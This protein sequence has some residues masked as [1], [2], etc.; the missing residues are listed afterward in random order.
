MKRFVLLF[1]LA[2]TALYSFGQIKSDVKVID[3]NGTVYI[4]KMYFHHRIPFEGD[5]V[6]VYGDEDQP[7]IEFEQNSPKP[8]DYSSCTVYIP[9]T[10][11]Y[12]GK[13]YTVRGIG[14]GCFQSSEDFGAFHLP[15]TIHYIDYQAFEGQY[16][17]TSINIPE[18]V[19]RIGNDAFSR[20]RSLQ[21][22]TIPASVKTIG[23][24]F[25]GCSSISFTV[26][27]GNANYCSSY[28]GCLLNKAKTELICANKNLT[29]F[30]IPS[31]ITKIDANA[32]SDS[33]L[34]QL[35]I[36]S[37]VQYLGG[38]RDCLNLEKLTIPHGVK[39]YAYYGF[40]DCGKNSPSG[41]EL[42]IDCD[43]PYTDNNAGCY[44]GRYLKK[45]VFGKHVTKIP[46]SAFNDCFRI[47]TIVFTSENPPSATATDF[48]FEM[49][50]ED[51]DYNTN[52]VS[53]TLYVP[54]GYEDHYASWMSFTYYVIYD[55][56]D[57]LD[58]DIPC[59]S[60]IK[61]FF[62]SSFDKDDIKYNTVDSL[63]YIGG[64]SLPSSTTAVTLSDS[65][66]NNDSIFTV[67]GILGGAFSG[68]KLLRT[69]TIPTTISKIDST[70]FTNCVRLRNINFA[71][72]MAQWVNKAWRPLAFSDYTLKLNGEEVENAVIPEGITELKPYAFY[73]CTSMNTLTLPSTLKTI[74]QNAL[75]NCTS[76]TDIYSYARTPQTLNSI[77]NLSNVTVHVPSDLLSTYQASDWKKAKAIVADIVINTDSIR[78][79]EHANTVGFLK[80]LKL[81]PSFYPA[82]ATN[83]Y[84]NWHTSDSTIATVDSTGIVRA[85][86]KPGIVKI[87]ASISSDNTITD[88][89]TITVPKVTAVKLIVNSK[90]LAYNDSLKLSHTILPAVNDKAVVKYSLKGDPGFSV[91]STGL[92]TSTY[93]GKTVV[94]CTYDGDSTDFDSCI[95]NVYRDTI[96]VTNASAD[97]KAIYLDSI[98]TRQNSRVVASFLI[99]TDEAL[100]GFQA[101]ICLPKG[102]SFE[103]NSD[104]SYNCTPGSGTTS[105][106]D[107]QTELQA[108]NS[109][110]VLA[111]STTTVVPKCTGKVLL[112]LVLDVDSTISP[113]NFAIQL[114]NI[115]LSNVNG[116]LTKEA[117][118]TTLLYVIN[119]YT[120]ITAM[121]DVDN[122]GSV[123]SAD[124][125][126]V[127]NK[128]LNREVPVFVTKAADLDSNGEIL[129]NDA[130]KVM[131]IIVYGSPSRSAKTYNNAINSEKSAD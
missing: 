97:A 42:D 25:D 52:G 31:T 124:A 112:T 7:A 65:V 126:L 81:T 41:F 88:T 12:E 117:D 114:K 55:R 95:V 47:N 107:L 122:D 85:K 19:T 57:G 9:S 11:M 8:S 119:P 109:L 54:Y 60:S 103:K 14:N 15:N 127:V 34:K 73:E 37:T 56:F 125:V 102:V 36:P 5:S 68:Y 39:F 30:E 18:S 98:K 111:T 24:A 106:I 4:A 77:G 53:P 43:D 129:V 100:A 28:E 91:D 89:C 16:N 76:L 3:S 108:D 20:C 61:T 64:S 46:R 123:R 110:R 118:Q 79:N 29:S 92:V 105:G 120:Y 48:A 94:Y 99:N 115:A 116:D 38:I 80:T 62:M 26:N 23:R 78:L 35:N 45:V 58:R 101:D 104:G 71:G 75:Y 90:K 50:D 131:N 121:G 130:V 33:Q 74:G 22:L 86:A 70:A 93:D 82:G 32:F 40:G 17:M 51:A 69:V 13:T 27:S 66:V 128:A 63:V 10:V 83:A 21:S 59:F 96:K 84:V 1:F 44:A 67:K 2:I 87:W 113:N 72:T 6:E 49:D